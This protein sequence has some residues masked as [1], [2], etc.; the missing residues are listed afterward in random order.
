[1]AI[2]LA[3]YTDGLF[4]SLTFAGMPFLEQPPLYFDLTALAFHVAGGPS[5]LAARPVV[6][7]LGVVWVAAIALLVRHVAG[8][9]PGLLAG[10][11]LAVA[12]TFT[13]E[14]RRFGVDVALVSFLSLSMALLYRAIEADA[15]RVDNRWWWASLGALACAALTKGIVA[16]FLFVTPTVAYA[17]VARDW[18][19]LAAMFR[20]LSLLAFFAPHLLWALV[21]YDSG[22][23]TFLFEHFV[24]NTVGRVIHTRFDVFGTY[25]LPYGDIGVQYPWWY[26]LR[27]IPEDALP[28][29]L[30]VPFALIEQRTRGGLRARDAQSRLTCLA[31]CWACVPPLLLS[32][33]AYK[34]RGHLG[35]SSTALVVIG[36]LWL[37]R[38]LPD[39][40]EAASPRWLLALVMGLY[41]AA[42][43]VL[44]ACFLGRPA[45]VGGAHL[46]IGAAGA[47]ALVA[48]AG[49]LRVR[50]GTLALYALLGALSVGL[51][52]D[53]SPGSNREIEASR[54][55][56]AL[57]RW[58]V[59]ET[60]T[61][62]IGVF[63]PSARLESD[64][65]GSFNE[66]SA[67]AL[68]WWS[69]RPLVPLR[70][71]ADIRAFLARPTPAFFVAV[72]SL[73]DPPSWPH[74]EQ[75]VGWVATGSNRRDAWTLVANL[76]AAAGR[77]GP[78]S[79]PPDPDQV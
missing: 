9:R 20:P 21:L 11:L 63:L 65:V 66:Q 10:A 16:S 74:G 4:R 54:S 44:V 45:T 77:T 34:G 33:S 40:A 5:V 60:G 42:P 6:A 30:A 15:P 47:L 68:A 76:A 55:T 36:A 22:G 29:V 70:S 25:D 41:T 73:D 18:R 12:A 57:A 2:A 37:A 72:H 69:G 61:A 8:P 51:V 3:Q 78:A 79:P 48:S 52:A 23:V 24:N 49:A 19:V 27:E 31:L 1:M 13:G 62:P 7:L 39:I 59:A 56:D 26:F 28:A 46:A 50:N 75:G 35:A 71:L 53:F 17:L 67:G 32:F 38:R 14:V 58:V 43:L 64:L